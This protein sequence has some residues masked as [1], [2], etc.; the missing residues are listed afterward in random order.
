MFFDI[1]I[2][3]ELFLCQLDKLLHTVESILLTT[4]KNYAVDD[5][6]LEIDFEFLD[7]LYDDNYFI[8]IQRYLLNLRQMVAILLNMFENQILNIVKNVAYDKEVFNYEQYN[9][10]GLA[11]NKNL[12]K[13]LFLKG[14]KQLVI[15]YYKQ[16]EQNPFKRMFSSFANV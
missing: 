14:G 2:D 8:Q 4:F 12:T 10:K 5:D 13:L 3:T 15:D 16:F 11:N 9:S 6:A 1:G 7:N